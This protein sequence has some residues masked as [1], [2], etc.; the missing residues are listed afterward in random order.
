MHLGRLKPRPSLDRKIRQIRIVFEQ[1]RDVDVGMLLHRV[2]DAI[3]DVFT[4][5]EPLDLLAF[6]SA[7]QATIARLRAAL[8]AWEGVAASA[9]E[10]VDTAKKVPWRHSK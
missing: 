8:S 4:A 2:D 7:L 10:S 5:R 6:A 9:G 1:S 3:V